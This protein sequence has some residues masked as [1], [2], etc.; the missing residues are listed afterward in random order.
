MIT[1]ITGGPGMG[2]TALAVSMLVDQ[3]LNRPI[4]TNIRGLS[5]DHSKLPKLDEW[6]VETPNDQGTSE[7][8][9]TFPPG[10][11]V[12]IDE[13]QQFFRPRASG[14]KV[15]PYISA[16]E[17]HR[18][19]GIDFI[20]IT[21]GSGL[22]DSNIKKLVKG[23][24]HIFLKSSYVGCF[25]Y[26]KSEVINEEDK[27][28]IAL[29]S[30]RKY[31]LPSKVFS[32]YK[33]AE[34]HTK[35]PRAKLPLAAY[36]LVLAIG[37]GGWLA[38]Q[39]SSR[40]GSAVSGGS[41]DN[42]SGVQIGIHDAPQ[43]AQPTGS[44][45]G[46][47]ASVPHSLIAAMIPDDPFN[48]LSAPIYAAVVPPVVAPEIIGCIQ[49]AS[50]C[51]CYT[52]QATPILIPLPQCRSRAAGHFYDPYRQLIVDQDSGSLDRSAPASS[53]DAVDAVKTE[54]APHPFMLSD[55]PGPEVSG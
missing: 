13:C 25:R 31:K 12:V 27:T 10:S 37:G 8:H 46:V 40:I 26:E 23:G 49:S 54:S 51:T 30:R 39:A 36:L 50:A 45:S 1:L 21:Q 3:Y 14:S 5:L 55:R 44:A 42:Q 9:F 29:A 16:F 4:F 38:Y 48:P 2:K 19:R 33:S 18:H 24:L 34:L 43:A 47:P 20:L 22:L 11:V 7:H 35:H 32:L 6:T 41:S 53:K 52:Q 28:A 15:P 17:T